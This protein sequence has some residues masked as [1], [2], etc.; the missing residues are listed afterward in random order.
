MPR[1]LIEIRHSDEYEGCVKAL[2]AI[3]NFGSHLV[4]NAEFGCE[5]GEHAGWLIVELD[6]R[7]EALPMIPPKLRDGARIVQLRKWTR[8]EIEAMMKELEA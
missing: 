6:T 4:T 3:V 7:A 2:D 1:F 5:D 8:A